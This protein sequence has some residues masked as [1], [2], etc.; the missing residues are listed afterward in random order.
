MR[1]A[2]L[3]YIMAIKDARQRNAVDRAINMGK[4][5]TDCLTRW[6]CKSS[7]ILELSL[8]SMNSNHAA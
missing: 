4:Q 7:S 3:I 2:L 5:Q 6:L 1:N 8:W